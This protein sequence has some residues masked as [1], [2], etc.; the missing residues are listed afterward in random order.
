[1]STRLIGRS[2]TGKLALLIVLHMSFAA[3]AQVSSP[4]TPPGGSDWLA[5]YVVP[6]GGEYA[7]QSLSS[8]AVTWWQWALSFPKEESP[9]RDVT[10]SNCGTKQSDEMWFLVGA[11]GGGRVRRSCT[12]PSGRALFFPVITTTFFTLPGAQSTC[13]DNTANVAINNDHLAYAQ[14]WINGVEIPNVDKHR[15][16]SPDCFH[17]FSGE[18][19][20]SRG[21]T[22]YPAATDGYWILLR[23]L[24]PGEYTVKFRAKYNRPD[25]LFG[26]MAQDV[27]YRLT[28]KAP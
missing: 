13:R 17:I 8:Y 23:P 25:E 21:S 1:M 24:P 16:R 15:A 5:Q 10:G 6:P 14:A 28:V 12:V 4:S 3:F 27:E 7:G 20:K 11:Y 19:A 22:G 2:A 26:S 9:M 18:N